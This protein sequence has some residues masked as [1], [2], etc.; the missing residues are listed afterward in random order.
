MNNIIET[1]NEFRNL[2]FSGVRMRYI[3]ELY[4][5]NEFKGELN[6]F[7]NFNEAF[8]ELRKVS[9][10]FKSKLPKNYNKQILFKLRCKK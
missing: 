7:Y 5:E 4:V 10:Y 3:I 2:D 8:N 1:L 6:W 9:K